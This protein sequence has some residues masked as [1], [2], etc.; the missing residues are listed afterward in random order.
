[1]DEYRKDLERLLNRNYA[2]RLSIYT[3]K[4]S[5]PEQDVFLNFKKTNTSQVETRDS[6]KNDFSKSKGHSLLSTT[7]NEQDDTIRSPQKNS[8]FG[9]SFPGLEESLDQPVKGQILAEFGVNEDK[10][11]LAGLDVQPANKKGIF[12]DLAGFGKG[13]R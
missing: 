4:P 6:H 12:L 11:L 3:N 5:L 10:K 7:L 8:F 1:M 9:A 13:L 2:D